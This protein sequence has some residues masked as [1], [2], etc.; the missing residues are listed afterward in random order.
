MA[1]IKQ[2]ELVHYLKLIKSMWQ[3]SAGVDKGFNTYLDTN[4]IV[5]DNYCPATEPV[6][7]IGFTASL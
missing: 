3:L 2:A 6:A 5:V 1:L 4:F 7:R